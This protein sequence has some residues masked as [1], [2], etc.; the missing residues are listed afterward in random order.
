MP[1]KR[2][3]EG[4]AEVYSTFQING[5]QASL[6]GPKQ[7]ALEYLHRFPTVSVSELF[8][9]SGQLAHADKTARDAA[10]YAQSWLLTHYLMLGSP[11]RKA[12][13]PEFVKRLRSGIEPA[14]AFRGAFKVDF[15]SMETEVAKYLAKGIFEP[16]RFD[17]NQLMSEGGLRVLH[18]CSVY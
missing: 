4:L 10:F 8:A 17:C 6:G 12:Q 5:N 7:E 2:L 18:S 11:A 1:A 13:Y 14:T 3:S 9:S 15:T 16:A